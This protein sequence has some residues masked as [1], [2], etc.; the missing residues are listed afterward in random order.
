MGWETDENPKIDNIFPITTKKFPLLGNVACGE[1][2]FADEQFET[3]IEASSDIKADFC[4][5][6]KGDSMTG[7]RIFDGDI[8]FIQKQDMV[9]NGEVAAVLIKDDATLKRVYYDREDNI[10]QLVAENPLYKTMR[11]TGE[12]LNQIRV[13][14]RAV[15]F[16]SN[17]K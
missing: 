17:I 3:F 9:N 10:L 4:L 16:Q 5:R 6:A 13:L 7:I 15:A 1:P 12:E 14:G 8:V 2:I 11:Y